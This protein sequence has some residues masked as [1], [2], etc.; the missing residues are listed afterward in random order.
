[1]VLYAVVAAFA[2]YFGMYAFRKPF[3][4]AT[5]EGE[6]FFGTGLD[7][8]TAFVISQI[9]GYTLSKYAGIKVVS[10]VASER[11]A[12]TLVALIVVAELGLV[13]FGVLPGAFMAIGLFVNGL[14]LG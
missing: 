13:M 12:F 1:M 8:K 2:T 3:A 11:R 4:A 10:E 5:Y 9:V 6:T 7:L 14:S